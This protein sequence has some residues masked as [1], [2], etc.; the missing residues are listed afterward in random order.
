MNSSD[1]LCHGLDFEQR[2]KLWSE[3]EDP[4]HRSQLAGW[5]CDAHPGSECEASV[6]CPLC[7][8]PSSAP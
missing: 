2:L 4:L 5:V 1:D 8:G 7:D 3:E 6:A